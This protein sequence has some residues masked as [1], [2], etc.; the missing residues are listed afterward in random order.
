R[1]ARILREEGAEV[2][3]AL[4]VLD[5]L[6]GGADRLAREGIALQ[7]L[8]LLTDILTPEEIAGPGPQSPAGESRT[9]PVAP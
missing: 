5:R 1:A 4:A 6:N 7:S 2:V 9:D 3:Q 8:F